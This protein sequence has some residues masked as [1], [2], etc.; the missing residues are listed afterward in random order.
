MDEAADELTGSSWDCSILFGTKL[1]AP[2][3]YVVMGMETFNKLVR[4][5]PD[6]GVAQNPP[7]FLPLVCWIYCRFRK[8]GLVVD[9]HSI[10]SV[11]SIRWPLRQVIAA[12]ERFTA[13]RAKL[14]ISPHNLWTRM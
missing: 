5:R 9:H 1:L 13:R 8:C 2:L 7:I 4:E 14:N 12:L 11:K 6:I 10:W 3:R